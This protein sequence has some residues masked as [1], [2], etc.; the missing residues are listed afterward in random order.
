MIVWQDKNGNIIRYSHLDR[1]DFK[2]GDI[3]KK[4]QSI[5]IM[6]NS[7]TSTNTHLH[8]EIKDKKGKLINPRN[9]YIS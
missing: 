6:G 2:V 8:L 1:A 4:G 5:A 7:G 3:I 9:Y